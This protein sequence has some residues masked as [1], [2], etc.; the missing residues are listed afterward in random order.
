MIPAILVLEVLQTV[1]VLGVLVA[2]AYGARRLRRTL[3][4]GRGGDS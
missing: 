1:A 2:T 3:K 4:P